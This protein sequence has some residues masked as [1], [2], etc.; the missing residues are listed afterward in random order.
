[1]VRL[2]IQGAMADLLRLF[3]VLAEA[4]VEAEADL[5]EQAA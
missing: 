4:L 2:K 1:L 5:V 3:R